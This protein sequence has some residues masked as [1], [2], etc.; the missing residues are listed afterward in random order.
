M[1][2]RGS[3]KPVLFFAFKTSIAFTIRKKQFRNGIAVNNGILTT[4]IIIQ[5]GD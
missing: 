4:I 1:A 3:R 5:K 2:R